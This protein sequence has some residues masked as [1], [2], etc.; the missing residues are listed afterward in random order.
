MG[1]EQ[2]VWIYTVY[3]RVYIW[4]HYFFQN[5]FFIVSAQLGENLIYTFGQVKDSLD[6][7][8]MTIYLSLDKYR[9]LLFPH[10]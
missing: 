1:Y 3:N 4:F 9:I 5:N 8:I 10:P 7:Y 2:T 6:K